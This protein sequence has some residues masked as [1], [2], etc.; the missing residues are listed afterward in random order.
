MEN[1]HGQETRFCYKQEVKIKRGFYRGMKGKII[2]VKQEGGT[3][4]YILQQPGGNQVEVS[5]ED[6]RQRYFFER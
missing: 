5:E 2:S 1:N 3:N 6:I 4:R